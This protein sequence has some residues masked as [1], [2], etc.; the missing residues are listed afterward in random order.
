MLAREM[1]R[2]PRWP[3]AAAEKLGIRITW[4]VQYERARTLAR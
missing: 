3:M 4:P 1:L 2:N